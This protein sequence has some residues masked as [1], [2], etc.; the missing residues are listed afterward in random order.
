MNSD[1]KPMTASEARKATTSVLS[2]QDN[3][4]LKSISENIEK[5]AN[6]GGHEIHVSK[7]SASVQ[8]ILRKNGYG[9]HEITDEDQHPGWSMWKISW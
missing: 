7:I 6:D 8:T 5:T 3:K 2:I 4:M 1:F 9:V